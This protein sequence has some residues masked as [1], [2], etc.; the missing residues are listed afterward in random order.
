MSSG[1]SIYSSNNIRGAIDSRHSAQKE[2]TR[3]SGWIRWGF[4]LVC[5]LLKPKSQV[6]CI[7]PAGT[8]WKWNLKPPASGRH[9]FFV[10]WVMGENPLGSKIFPWWASVWRAAFLDKT[11]KGQ[12]CSQ[13]WG[14]PASVN[15]SLGHQRDAVTLPSMGNRDRQSTPTA[16]HVQKWDEASLTWLSSCTDLNVLIKGGFQEIESRNFDLRDR[17]KGNSCLLERLRKCCL[18]EEWQP[19][20]KERTFALEPREPSF[21]S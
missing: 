16:Q 11:G 9:L 18:T 2:D 15:T 19:G 6:A 17:G 10:G 21:T 7:C 14:L 8:A 3:L 20:T 4:S 5:D 1:N 12:S 13:E